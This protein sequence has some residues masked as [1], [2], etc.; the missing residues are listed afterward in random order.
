MESELFGHEKGSF[1]GAASARKGI[2]ELAEG[3]TL[4]LDEIGEMP[5]HLQSKLLGVLDSREIRRIGAE[6]ARSVNVRVIA[7]TSV[8]IPEAIRQKRFR[9]DLYYR[10]S[11]IRI[12]MP[13]LRDRTEDIPSLCRYLLNKIA[14][15]R[16]LI[17]SNE[18]IA[19]LQAYNWLGNVRELSNILERSVILSTDSRVYPSHLLGAGP[20]DPSRAAPRDHGPAPPEDIRYL[21]EVEREHIAKALVCF[22]GNLTRAARALGKSLSTIKRK[23]RAYGLSRP[24]RAAD[25]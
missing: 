16:H 17:L 11:V 15:G 12:H 3:G 24:S 10:L 1:T 2:F 21:E 13:A 22:D 25:S 6:S 7:A 20:N 23:V 5:L 8:D 19:K 18:E 9:E 4:L 14:G